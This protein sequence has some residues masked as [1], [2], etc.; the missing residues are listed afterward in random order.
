MLFRSIP[1]ELK[2]AAENMNL[3]GW[4]KWKKFLLPAVFP[5]YVTGAI[6]A[7][8][9]SWNASIVAEV[10]NWGDTTLR[11]HGLGAYIT[12]NTILGNFPQIALGVVVMCLWVTVI[13]LL[14]WRRLYRFAEDRYRL[15]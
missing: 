4:L 15:G 8:G 5:Y 10:I 2:L 7:A 3:R 11:A 14:F 6:T 13:N 9:G 12:E 1:T